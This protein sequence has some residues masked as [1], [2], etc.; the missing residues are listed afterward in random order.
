[1]AQEQKPAITADE[2]TPA[3]KAEDA[4]DRAAERVERAVDKTADKVEKNAEAKAFALPAGVTPKDLKE[5]GD[6]R[7]AFEAVTEASMSKDIFDN[8]VN[9]LVDADRDRISKYKDTKPDWKPLTDRVATLERSWKE[10]Y[11]KSFDLDEK[12]V[13][14]T[15]NYVVVAQGEISDP[16]A[17]IGNW[18]VQPNVGAVMAAAKKPAVNAA[19]QATET[20]K[21]AGG[22]TN[23]D[24]GRNVAVA[25]YPAGHGLPAVDASL[26][27]ELPDIWR[28][29]LPDNIDGQK[30]TANLIA[31]LN[32]VGTQGWP[33]DIN[34]AYRIVAHRVL[35]AMYDVP[36]ESVNAA[37]N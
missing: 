33:D 18:P 8:I 5:E 11:G 10:K 29:D 28:F 34:E 25:R 23:L 12:V 27:H 21:A 20:N 30:L 15:N 31:H 35:L 16:K 9:R 19:E 32:Q 2:P 13:F 26:I 36:V 24:K 1:M 6:V 14:G 4:V 3:K 17:L 7:N 22:D 37:R